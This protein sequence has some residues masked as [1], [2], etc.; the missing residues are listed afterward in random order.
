MFYNMLPIFFFCNFFNLNVIQDGKVSTVKLTLM[1][2]QHLP[3]MK[4][5][6]VWTSRHQ[7]L[8]QSVETVP[9]GMM[10]MESGA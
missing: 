8:V 2:V 9:R 1:A 6:P 7:E 5:C 4:E 10:V 3:A